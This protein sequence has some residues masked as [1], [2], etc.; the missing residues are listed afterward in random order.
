VSPQAATLMNAF[1]VF[2]KPLS[3]LYLKPF[4]VAFSARCHRLAGATPIK[5]AVFSCEKTL[6]L[7]ASSQQL[8]CKTL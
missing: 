8:V 2:F 4:V 1:A 5:A 3:Y 6:G 7:V